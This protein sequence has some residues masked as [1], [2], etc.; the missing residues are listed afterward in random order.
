MIDSP[1]PIVRPR[2][3]AESAPN[4]PPWSSFHRY[5]LRLIAFVLKFVS[6]HQSESWVTTTGPRFVAAEDITS[7]MA[8]W[9]S[10]RKP[11]AASTARAHDTTALF[12]H[13]LN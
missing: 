12:I 9:A 5:P 11:P 6:S 10:D 3:V 4:S 13:T 7:V 2:N 1:G 8:S